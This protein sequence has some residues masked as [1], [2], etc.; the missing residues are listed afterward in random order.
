MTLHPAESPGR[1]ASAPFPT[2]HALLAPDALLA[3][4]A[5]A[6]PL[7]RAVDCSLLRVS[8]NDTYLIRTTDGR[9]ILRVYGKD[10]HTLA[11]TQ[12]EL[13]LL[14]HLADHGASVAVPIPRADGSLLSAL[15]APEGLRFAAVFTHAPG[16]MPSPHPVGDAG[17]SYHYGAALAA[18][19][20]AAD[21]FTNP[22]ARRP[23]D[24][25]HYLDRSLASAR[26]YM[27]HRTHDLTELLGLAGEVRAQV[28]ALA[29]RG[30]DWGVVHGDPF[31]AN[32]FIT[33]DGRVTWYDFDFCGPGWRAAEFA[34]PYH[35]AYVREAD[36]DERLWAAFIEGY[37]TRRTVTEHDLAAVPVFLTAGWI[38]SLGVNFEKGPIQ[39]IEWLDDDFITER[40]EL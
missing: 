22:H 7:G 28:T 9:Y 16:Q 29:T 2:A 37:H 30:L 25:A 4:V 5:A 12:Y 36:A 38:W 8:W 18:L 20:A 11:E 21:T 27:M 13:E 23:L 15:C 19:H 31:S 34:G 14:Q 24:L 6:Y 40:L 17:Q 39:G 1:E 10:W 33:D 32:S 3:A 26:P 35:A